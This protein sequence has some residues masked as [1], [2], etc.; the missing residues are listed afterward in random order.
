MHSAA[1]LNMPRRIPKAIAV[2]YPASYH[3]TW[4]LWG[5]AANIAGRGG[6]STPID[7]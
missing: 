6:S 5:I 4:Q 3:P 1:Q 2:V 7:R